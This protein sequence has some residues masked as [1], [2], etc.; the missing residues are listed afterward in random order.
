MKRV[1][2]RDVAKAAGVSITTVSKALNN[3]PDVNEQT[4]KRIQELV[5]KMNYV[6]DTAGRS[7]GGITQ[8]VIGL[9]INNLMPTDPS[10]AVYSHLSGVCHVCKDYNI[11]FLL[12]TTDLE[13]QLQLPL[14]RLC[15][16]K[17]LTGLVCSGFRPSDPYVS[18][19]G[20]IDIPC[21]CIDLKAGT[22]SVLEVTIDNVR[23]A[24]E[25]VSFLIHNGRKEIAMLAGQPEIEVVHLR[26]KGYQNALTRAKQRLRSHRILDADFNQELAYQKAK[27]LLLE[28]PAVDAFFCASDI[29]ALGVCHAIEDVGKCVGGDISVVGFDDIPIARYLYGGITTIRQD[30]Y[31]MGYTAGRLVCE[32]ITSD[33]SAVTETRLLYELVVR[34]SAPGTINHL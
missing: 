8:P 17:G 31:N 27:R 30:F 28:D 24:D 4:K 34:G 15:L 26:T 16:S 33:S 3:Y 20:G 19:M 25:A 18:Q 21:V 7:M 12:I 11:D 1:S 14:K 6:P 13:S 22:P 2:I 5:E 29:M 9:L 23:A 10:G 32:K